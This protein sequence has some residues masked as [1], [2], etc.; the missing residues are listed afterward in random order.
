MTTYR[1]YRGLHGET[2]RV[3]EDTLA[4]ALRCESRGRFPFSAVAARLGEQRDNFA[5]IAMEVKLFEDLTCSR[6]YRASRFKLLAA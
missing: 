6:A 4:R 3:P 1:Q 5:N 2:V